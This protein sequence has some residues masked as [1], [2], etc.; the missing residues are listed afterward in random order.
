MKAFMNRAPGLAVLITAVLGFQCG[1]KPPEVA[2]AGEPDA[3]ATEADAGVLD[4]GVTDLDG[5]DDAL[6][7]SL[8][9]AYLSVLALYPPASSPPPT[10]DPGVAAALQPVGH[11][12]LRNRRQRHG[13][14]RRPGLRDPRL[15]LI[16]QVE[17]A[18]IN[19]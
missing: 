13:R 10:V 8:A 2:D 6:E 9:Q 16:R 5:L 11:A 7:L 3:G 4:A 19:P 15:P 17:E 14:S 18:T 12:R 1:T